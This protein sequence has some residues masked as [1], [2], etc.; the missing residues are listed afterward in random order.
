N[1]P[2]PNVGDT[3]TFTLRLTNSGPNTATNVVVSDPL[4]AGLSFVSATPVGAYDSNTGLWTVGTVTTTVPQ[5]LL[6]RATV[7]SP[8]AQTNT[9]SVFHADQFDPNPGNNQA[10]IVATPQQAE[11]A[12]TKDVSNPTPNV[13]DT[14]T[15]TVTL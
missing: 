14:I 11:L 12:L 10:S 15:F 3:I 13:G 4:P 7:I 9:V 6:I 5:T 8:D 2:T 1:N